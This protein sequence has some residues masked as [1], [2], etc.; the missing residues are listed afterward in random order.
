MIRDPI[1]SD[2]GLQKLELMKP[3]LCCEKKSNFAHV[4]IHNANRIWNIRRLYRDFE[5]K[6]IKRN[7]LCTLIK[8]P[9]HNYEMC[10][11]NLTVE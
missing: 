8:V 2:T 11:A 7:G 1:A 10:Q 4:K 3:L 6:Q 5:R 9:P